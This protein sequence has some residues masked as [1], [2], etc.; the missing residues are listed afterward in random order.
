MN[1]MQVDNNVSFEDETLYCVVA[2]GIDLDFL[3]EDVANFIGEAVGENDYSD[4]SDDHTLIESY[5]LDSGK[6]L[7]VKI[8]D[9]GLEDISKYTFVV[10]DSVLTDET[11]G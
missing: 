11:F 3:Q 9:I 5:L 6:K 4:L 1:F 2:Q 7:H 8:S 10:S